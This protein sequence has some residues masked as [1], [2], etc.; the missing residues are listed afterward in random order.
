MEHNIHAGLGLGD[1]GL[2]ITH[3]LCLNVNVPLKLL[4]FFGF[5]SKY[6]S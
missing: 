3:Y 6:I 4:I 1:P 5:V 2:G